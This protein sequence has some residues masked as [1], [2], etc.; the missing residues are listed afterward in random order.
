MRY[1]ISGAITGNGEAWEDFKRAEL[2]LR[3]NGH[4][5]V[6]PLAVARALPTLGY[7]EYMTLD[8][9]LIGLCDCVFFLKGWEKSKGAKAEY[10]YAKVIG[11]EIH[12]ESI[13]WA[14]KKGEEK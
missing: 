13:Q 10:Y 14:M 11:K 4:E 9:S 3:L 12:F 8:F 6:N 5:V 7:E 2:W 1:Y